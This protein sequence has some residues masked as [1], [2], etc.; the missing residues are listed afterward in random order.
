V[1]PVYK[2][3]AYLDQ[4][5][6]S[7]LDQTFRDLE[8]VLVDDGSPDNCGAMCDRWA[9]RDS[10]VRAVH[11]KN[12]GLSAAR[13]TGIRNATGE[14]VLFLDSDDWW[15]KDSVLSAIA[16]QLERTAVDV[17]SFNYR[18]SYNG[19]VEPA[20]FS[21]EAPSSDKVEGLAEIVQ[22]GYWITGACNKAIR[23]SLL[24]ENGLYFR[25]GITSEDIDWTLRLGLKAQ[26]FAFA[27]VCVFVYRQRSASIS[28]SVSAKSVGVLRDNVRRCVALLKDEEPERM[29]MM[30]P[31][32]A[33]QYATMVYNIAVLPKSERKQFMAD[34]KQMSY[35]LACSGD[36]KVRLIYRCKRLMGFSV[37][38]ALL[39]LRNRLQYIG[40]GV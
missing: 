6:Q 29:E 17:L 2:V 13:N 33:Y 5:V 10:R 11:Q 32:V 39:R 8:V 18:K 4:C 23:R 19:S 20:Y 26:T 21:E 37:T 22:Q 7:V 16:A 25:E 24:T 12:G 28:H 3:E 31:F 36:S 15:E 1:I 9:E 27:N 30:Q 35:L 14:Y 38:M 34:V 40:K